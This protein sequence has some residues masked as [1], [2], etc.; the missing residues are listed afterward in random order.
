MNGMGWKLKEEN[1]RSNCR[2]L[3]LFA[4]R[5][6]VYFLSFGIHRSMN[7]ESAIEK[8]HR[9][10]KEKETCKSEHRRKQEEEMKLLTKKR[11]KRRVE[12]SRA[13]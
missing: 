9:I 11:S 2:K 13:C 8:L 6:C 4:T 7:V 1:K 3:F 10:T 12:K 5:S